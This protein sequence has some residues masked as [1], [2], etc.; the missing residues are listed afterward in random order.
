MCL[1]IKGSLQNYFL[2]PSLRKNLKTLI[3]YIYIYIYIYRRGVLV[4][5]TKYYIY[6]NYM[7]QFLTR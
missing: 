5:N 3:L 2:K 6:Y 7:N 1:Y 4:I